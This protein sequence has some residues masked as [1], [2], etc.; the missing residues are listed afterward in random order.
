M[1]ERIDSEVKQWASAVAQDASV[2]LGAPGENGDRAQ[3]TL[4]L[5][6]ISDPAA[7]RTEGGKPPP[8]RVELRYL[9]TAAANTEERAHEVLG[10]LLFAALEHPRFEVELGGIGSDQW[11]ALGVRLRPCFVLRVPLEVERHVARAPM[12]RTVELRGAPMRAVAG[13]VVG[14]GE[15]PLAGARV[16]LPEL[17]LWATTDARGGFAF[18]CIP[19]QP[20]ARQVEVR[21]RGRSMTVV[22]G[23]TTADGDWR[24]HFNALED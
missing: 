8:L 12:V 1:I 15:V 14:P 18:A 9:V 4:S 16:G 3:I 21:A 5:L 20:A 13:V 24:I 7:R 17:D 2:S 11:R 19:A 23:G 10:Q 6:Q 22:A